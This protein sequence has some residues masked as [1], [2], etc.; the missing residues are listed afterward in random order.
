M[1][2]KE[3]EL[4]PGKVGLIIGAFMVIVHLIWSLM[5][6]SGIAQSFLNWIFQLH[7]V[8]NSFVVAGFDLVT[9][10]YLLIVVFVVGYILGWIFAW[11][12]NSIHKA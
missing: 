4:N 8:K 12:H 3:K 1:A 7:F 11:V 9:A 5:V 6:A 10:I 2:V